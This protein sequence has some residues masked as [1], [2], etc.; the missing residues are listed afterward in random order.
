MVNRRK[1]I[2]TAAE[3]AVRKF[4]LPYFPEA[5]RNALQGSQDQGDLG[6][7]GVVCAEVKG[8]DAARNLN[9]PALLEDWMKQTEAEVRNSG[10]KYGVLVVQRRGYGANNSGHWFAYVT[11]NDLSDII[12]SD[13]RT[14]EPIYVRMELK[15]FVQ[16]LSDHGLT[17]IPM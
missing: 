15:D 10:M 1:N 17:D 12:H 4:L 3:T 2:G 16:I 14:K 8:G 6:G 7:L 11:Q 5:R 9:S 13:Y